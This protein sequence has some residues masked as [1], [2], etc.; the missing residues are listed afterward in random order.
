MDGF[1][2]AEIVTANLTKLLYFHRTIP[3]TIKPYT[4]K[5]YTMGVAA[6]VETNKELQPDSVVKFC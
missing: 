3:Y 6:L 4:I 2:K 1:R 5:P